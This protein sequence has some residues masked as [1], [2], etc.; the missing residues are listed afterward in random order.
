[1]SDHQELQAQWEREG[2]ISGDSDP[3]PAQPE[4]LSDASEE[5]SQSAVHASTTRIPA[6]DVSNIV[7]ELS[8]SMG[9]A[10]TKRKASNMSDNEMQDP[11]LGKAH[12]A[13]SPKGDSSIASSTANPQMQLG[14]LNR[15]SSSSA[16][17]TKA[18]RKEVKDPFDFEVP[19]DDEKDHAQAFNSIRIENGPATPSAR[20][21]QPLRV[22]PQLVSSKTKQADPKRG[23]PKGSKPHQTAVDEGPRHN[24][25]SRKVDAKPSSNTKKRNLGA[26]A[27]PSTKREEHEQQSRKKPKVQPPAIK[28]L[29][30]DL[31]MAAE[32]SITQQNSRRHNVSLTSQAPQVN[33]DHGTERSDPI[34]PSATARAQKTTV[35]NPKN[36]KARPSPERGEAAEGPD[37]SVLREASNETPGSNE[38]PSKDAQDR[39]AASEEPRPEL[40]GLDNAW[41]EIKTAKCGIVVSKT[42]GHKTREIPVLQ[43]EELEELVALIEETTQLYSSSVPGNLESTVPDNT[44]YRQQDLLGDIQKHMDGLFESFKGEESDIIQD[45]Y[46]HTFPKIVTLLDTALI[47]R[48]VQLSDKSNV[49]ALGEIIRIQN[50]MATLCLRARG[51]LAKPSAERPTVPAARTMKPLLQSLQTSFG[52]E[53]QD[54]KRRLKKKENDARS[55]QMEHESSQR[56]QQ[57]W[58]KT[59]RRKERRTRIIGEA[60]SQRIT[61]DRPGRVLRLSQQPRSQEPERRTTEDQWSKE[62]DLELFAAV[63]ADE[64]GDLPGEMSVCNCLL[65]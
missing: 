30:E 58:E 25:R 21:V 41:R 47:A 14:K 16:Q 1:M 61:A 23:R 39:T 6:P 34:P 59:Q 50:M 9:H 40:F 22:L 15:P 54:R 27:A 38:S 12:K 24:L 62:Q 60:I 5:Q 63:F 29:T 32:D 2:G 42:K 35:A 10:Q 18:R 28:Y 64:L 56:A 37:D 48:R 11:R 26:T 45:I 52:T 4:E 20:R 31:D 13:D 44:M 7:N 43:T 57:A 19:Q 55:E 8:L 36:R 3:L 51:P 65:R 49:D 17:V 53:L 33:G 46:A